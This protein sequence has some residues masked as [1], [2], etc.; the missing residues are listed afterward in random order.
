MPGAIAETATNPNKTAVPPPTK[1]K[2]ETLRPTKQPMIVTGQNG[3]KCWGSLPHPN[4][5][6]SQPAVE[7]L[8]F[9]KDT[10]I[11]QSN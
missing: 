5:R 6:P 8:E 3:Q 4:L 2:S 1:H 11:L 7:H 10:S 9:S